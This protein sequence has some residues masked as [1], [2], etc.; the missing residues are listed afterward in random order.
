MAYTYISWLHLVSFKW[1][2]EKKT[3]TQ[4]FKDGFGGGD[5][6]RIS[7]QGLA[8]DLDGDGIDEQVVAHCSV[9]QK[10]LDVVDNAYDPASIRLSVSVWDLSLKEK[11]GSD[12]YWDETNYFELVD[13]NYDNIHTG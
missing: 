10:Q 2:S 11:I 12:Y 8:A 4:A 1:D 5:T 3:F 6:T 9:S 13:A 7:V